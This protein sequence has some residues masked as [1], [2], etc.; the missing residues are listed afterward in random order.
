[1]VQCGIKVKD[2]EKL[3]EEQNAAEVVV[4]GSQNAR[5]F[6]YLF[7]TGNWARLALSE[8]GS[9]MWARVRVRVAVGRGCSRIVD[10]FLRRSLLLTSSAASSSS[11]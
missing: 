2:K 5:T 9:N 8:S 10:F 3:Q 6:A 11:G 1:M 7:E 4:A